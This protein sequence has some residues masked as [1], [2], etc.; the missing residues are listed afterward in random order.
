MALVP[1]KVMPPEMHG[2]PM[3]PMPDG[4]PEARF[5]VFLPENAR[6]VPATVLSIF[7]V[8]RNH[9]DNRDHPISCGQSSD[10]GVTAVI[11]GPNIGTIYIGQLKIDIRRLQALQS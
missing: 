5:K 1:A 2:M 7:R 6:R 8:A 3:P 10:L 4:I 11:L 9:G